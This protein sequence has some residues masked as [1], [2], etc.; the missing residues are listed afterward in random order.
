MLASV[1]RPFS[2]PDEYAGFIR[3]TKAEFAIT[4][5]GHF[6][7]KLVHINLHR[8]WMQRFSETLP[9]VAHFDNV[10]GR[11]FITFRTQP[12]ASMLWDGAEAPPAAIMRHSESHSGFH[13]TTG[14][15]EFAAMSLPIAD[16]EA[17]GA[18]FGGS[19]FTPPR[20]ALSFIPDPA[21]ILRLRSLHEAAG[22]LAE[23]APHVI[24]CLKSARGLEQALI[25]ALAG[26]F[27]TRDSQSASLGRHRH[28]RI[29]QKFY[30]MLE[31]EPD[32][33][34]HPIEI[35]QQIGV[36][37]RTLATC[38]IDALGMGPFQYLRLRQM[39]LTHRALLRADPATTT[40]TE[41]A[42]AYAFWE[43]GR[44]AV[45]YRMLFGEPPSVTLR[46]PRATG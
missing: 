30:A 34:I 14:P 25:A 4:K 31:A 22:H 1:V 7:G 9:R 11:A 20:D 43:L 8:L 46:R 13:R 23:H 45:A 17:V 44:F 32:R 16:L 33:V 24:A 29:M 2:D 38:C 19:D 15:T 37:K 18:T 6:A 12:G 39:N 26:C 35:C 5:P 10:P 40:V 21:A 42:T 28:A 41:I 27:G 3:G 36:S